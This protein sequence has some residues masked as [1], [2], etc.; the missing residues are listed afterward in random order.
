MPAKTTWDTE[1]YESRHSFVWQHGE[2]L[3]DLL[4]P[5]PGECILD[6]GC[7]TGQLTA[8]IADAGAAVL[9]LDASPDMIGQARQNYP[10]LQFKLEDATAMQ[11]E[12][13]FDAVF[14]NAALHWM[15]DAAAVAKNIARALKP[16]GRFVAE[17]GGHGNIGQIVSAIETTIKRHT[18]TV[19]PGRTFFP[20]IPEYTTLLEAE[21]LEVQLAHLFDRPT[22]LEGETGMENWIHQ[23]K[24]YYFENVPLAQRT[25]ILAEVVAA[26]RPK[27]FRDG[28]WF[29]DYRRLRVVAVK[30]A[31]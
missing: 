21:G 1:L 14:S 28:V 16:G 3:L 11:F 25:S 15:L 13:E 9:G 2:G 4:A 22:P 31:E 8:K 20:S 19:P 26:L 27:L 10:R 23:F 7:G 12:N 5:R 18:G 30:P 29:A 24:W 17:L 6:L